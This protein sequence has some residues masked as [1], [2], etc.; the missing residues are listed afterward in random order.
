MIEPLIKYICDVQN[1]PINSEPY[2]ITKRELK[3]I[4]L[5]LQAVADSVNLMA[6][7]VERLEKSITELKKDISLLSS[8]VV[9]QGKHIERLEK[10]VKK[11]HK[12]SRQY[13]AD[14]TKWES[15]C[16]CPICKN[17]L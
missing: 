13:M 16:D 1:K 6:E 5:M 10:E 4:E 14:P 17:N 7:S 12:A 8:I 11:N 2:E 15:P 3:G 9:E